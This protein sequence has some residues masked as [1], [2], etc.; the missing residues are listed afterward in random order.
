M[1]FVILTLILHDCFI[2]FMFTL[3]ILIENEVE[4]IIK[5]SNISDFHILMLA[6]LVFFYNIYLIFYYY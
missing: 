5:S 2:V 6:F 4:I 1:Y 3:Y